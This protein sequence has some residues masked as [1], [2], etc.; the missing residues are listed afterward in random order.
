[1]YLRTT[2]CIMHGSA[3][4]PYAYFKRNTF[5]NNALLTVGISSPPAHAQSLTC[6]ADLLM[7]TAGKFYRS[8]E[9]WKIHKDILNIAH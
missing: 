9:I 2:Y 5:T 4:T 3:V 6:K 8:D 1:M 7:E